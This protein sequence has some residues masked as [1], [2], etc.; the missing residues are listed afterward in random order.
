MPN[1][2]GHDYQSAGNSSG[3]PNFGHTFGVEYGALEIKDVFEVQGIG[4]D[5]EQVR[6]GTGGDHAGSVFVHAGQNKVRPVTI[7][8]YITVGAPPAL[9]MIWA[10]VAAATTGQVERETLAIQWFDDAGEKVA[11]EI[12][13]REA[14][15][16]DY[17]GPQFDHTASEPATEEATFHCEVMSVVKS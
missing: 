11:V 2:S 16:S 4:E 8:R 5:T 14:W 12:N 15:M 3:D 9:A 1:S 17:K 13:F 6:H 7:K 10:K